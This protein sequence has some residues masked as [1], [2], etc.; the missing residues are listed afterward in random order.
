MARHFK[1]WIR[2]YLEYTYAS[3]A[4]ESLHFWTAVSTI[5]GAVRRRVLVN[6]H[7]FEISPNF[8]IVLVGPAGVVTKSTTLNLGKDLLEQVPDIRFGP[9]S[10]S[11]QGVADALSDSIIYFKRRPDDEIEKPTAMSA[12]TL[13]VSE[14][15][16]FL[17]PDDGQAVAFI[18]DV[19]DGKRH[20]YRHRTRHSGSPEIINPWMNMIAATTPTWI[21]NNIPINMVGE[22]LISR[23]TFVY[24][25]QKRHLV[26]RPS[27]L[28]R[29][30]EYYRMRDMLIEDL[31]EISNLVGEFQYSPEADKWMD[32]WYTN[33]ATSRP[34]YMASDR[35]GGYLGRK[36]T[37]LIKLAM[38][39]SLSSRNDL[40]FTKQDF[41]EASFY[42]EDAERN[43]IR[44]F[45][46]IGIVDEAR[47]VAEIIQFVRSYKM[48]RYVDLW[49]CVANI[50]KEQ[51]FRKAV[52]VA[53]KGEKVKVVNDDKGIPHLAPTDTVH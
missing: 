31:V 26:A 38:I 21:Q 37:F 7:I 3:E 44:V 52:E 32:E 43:M 29:G 14:L 20:T 50:M 10:G 30:G 27:K 39:M 41:E 48:I 13:A 12:I 53:Y 22:G 40:I 18:T 4:P 49:R 36:Q 8:Y 47:H 16:T 15:G 5:A 46:S 1:D 34:T 35:Y 45:E 25:E 51:D 9:D 11:W 24:A 28:I 33:H 17:K 23:I 42:L 19:W 6:E 2:A